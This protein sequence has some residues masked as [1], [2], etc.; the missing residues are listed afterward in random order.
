MEEKSATTVEIL[1][2]EYRIRGNAD[3]AYVEKVA[4][5]V[6]ERLREVTR[7]AAGQPAD[8]VAVLR[9]G[10]LVQ[11]GPPRDVYE[12][13]ADAW[14]AA[15]T[16]P[17]SVLTVTVLGADREGLTLRIGDD[18]AT[19]VLDG[20]GEADAGRSIR[21]LVRP[22]WASLGGDL[23]AVV[24]AVLYRG[25]HTDY[26]LSTPAGDLELREPGPP[27]AGVGDEVRWTLRRAWS[28][29]SGTAPP[30]GAT[31]RLGPG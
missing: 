5:F 4:R 27:R 31:P 1:G 3:G 19:L 8:R 28:L 15:M 23:R 7:G 12:R 22:D 13:P 14:V 16:G 9:G 21:V 6:D 29:G 11:V 26:R 24:R 18:R 17:A 25:P 30:E 2:R 20:H 10:R